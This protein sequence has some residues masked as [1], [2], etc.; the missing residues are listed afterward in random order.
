MPAFD[1]RF[2]VIASLLGLPALAFAA[3][4]AGLADVSN[5]ADVNHPDIHDKV[6]DGS[7][8]DPNGANDQGGEI[9][10]IANTPG[11]S[12]TSPNADGTAGFANQL[13]TVHGGIGDV[14][15]NAD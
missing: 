15:K 11:Q 13:E 2:L 8:A 9:H 5:Q 4:A 10:D 3:R 12:D 7:N 14:N 1:R 6:G